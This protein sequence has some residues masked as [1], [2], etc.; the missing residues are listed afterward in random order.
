MF[1]VVKIVAQAWPPVTNFTYY[2]NPQAGDTVTFTKW[3]ANNDS[4]RAGTGRIITEV[5]QNCV[6]FNQGTQNHDSTVN[7]VQ[8][9][10]IRSNPDIDSIQGRPFID[11]L[12]SRIGYFDSIYVINMDIDTIISDLTVTG[13]LSVTGYVNTDSICTLNGLTVFYING[14]SDI[15]GIK[16]DGSV[17]ATD[18]N[19]SGNIQADSGHFV[20]GITA[21]NGDFSG[22][23]TADS[24]TF[25][26][27][28]LDSVT[29]DYGTFDS[30]SINGYNLSVIIDTGTITCSTYTALDSYDEFSVKYSKYGN[31]VT[32]DFP[33]HVSSSGI[34]D[35]SYVYICGIPEN[36]NANDSVIVKTVHGISSPIGI[37][38]IDSS[39]VV[40]SDVNILNLQQA[41][42]GGVYA[43]MKI[44]YPFRTNFTPFISGTYGW[45]THLYITY[46]V[47]Q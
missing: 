33:P 24:A 30:V 6:H 35:G 32:L 44:L 8:I 28:I 17:D 13:N 10:T 21:G 3:S 2:W 14:F 27:L 42:G 15:C 18:G 39:E 9:D 19:F 47:K 20:N 16:G 4:V 7:Y 37:G 12:D 22:N 40:A 46:S 45:N 11:S 5:N 29:A 36:L 41:L 1:L 38:I 25:G 26:H 34:G 31:I 23:V 43:D